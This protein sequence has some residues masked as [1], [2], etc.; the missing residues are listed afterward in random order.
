M[1]EKNS[2][3][4]G[5]E[6]KLCISELIIDMPKNSRPKPKTDSPQPLTIRFLETINRKP[7]TMAGIDNPS[8]LKEI[9]WAVMVVPML[10]PKMIPTACCK[11]INPALMKPKTM[12]VVAD[13]DWI[14]AV[15]IVPANTAM[16]P[17]LEKK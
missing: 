7:S 14:T 17:F 6:L 15:T 9:N 2:R 8:N 13:E 5:K 11:L 4:V 10:A 16:T 1:L 3:N 12:T